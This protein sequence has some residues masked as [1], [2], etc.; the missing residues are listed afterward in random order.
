MDRVGVAATQTRH[1]LTPGKVRKR[2]QYLRRT[3]DVKSHAQPEEG[4]V[5]GSVGIRGGNRR[6]NEGNVRSAGRTCNNKT[7]KSRSRETSNT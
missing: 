2:K 6:M 5:K 7:P 4:E 3:R 1:V